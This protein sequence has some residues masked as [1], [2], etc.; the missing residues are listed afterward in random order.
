MSDAPLRIFNIT[1]ITR[2]DVNM[3]MEDTL[4][5]RR[6]YVYANVVAVGLKLLVQQF[7]LLIY[8]LHAGV[9]LFGRQ[10]KKIGNMATRDNHRMSRAHRV[11]IASAV[12]QLVIQRQ[13]WWVFTKQTWVVGVPL[14]FLFFFRPTGAVPE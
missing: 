2:N 3:D 5:G 11:G 10:L 8:Q 7:A 1:R 13:P 9:D 12:R 4:P 14:F 6:S